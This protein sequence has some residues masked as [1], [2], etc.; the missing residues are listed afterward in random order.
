MPHTVLATADVFL[1][2][3]DRSKANSEKCGCLCAA[4]LQMTDL[5]GSWRSLLYNSTASVLL[6]S[7]RINSSAALSPVFINHETMLSMGALTF[8]KRRMPSSTRYCSFKTNKFIHALSRHNKSIVHICG[9]FLCLYRRFDR[10]SGDRKE[11][12][13]RLRSE[14]SIGH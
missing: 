6:L 11:R 13:E 14:V 2:R 5:L 12:W 10:G 9:L 4:P 1:W 3:K 7:T 8:L